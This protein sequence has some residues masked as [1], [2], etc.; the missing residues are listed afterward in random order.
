MTEY[1]PPAW[2]PP[3]VAVDQRRRGLLW[4]VL[5][6]VV[7]VGVLFGGG[8]FA[9]GVIAGHSYRSKHQ[10]APAARTA[11]RFAPLG[12]GN[13]LRTYLLPVPAGAQKLK[14]DNSTFGVQTIGQFASGYFVDGV[15]EKA[16]LT[17]RRFA[18][19]AAT[20]WQDADHTLV[21]TH[22]LQFHDADGA[23]GY[24]LGQRSTY[25]Q[26]AGSKG[27][28]RIA[29][30]SRGYGYE[31]PALDKAGEHRAYLLCQ[32]GPLVLLMNFYSPKPIDRAADDMMFQRQFGA[33][34]P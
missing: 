33:L 9:T 23:S 5:I 4:P 24:V 6:T 26:D 15:F 18:V 8:A 11:A 19:S 16:Q 34:T 7:V 29:A 14:I 10:P 30:P 28:Y 32:D 1:G 2:V 21:E 12:D 25:R 31:P 3:P 13:A 27:T 17:S 20:E 22:L